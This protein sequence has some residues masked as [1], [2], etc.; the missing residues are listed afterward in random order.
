MTPTRER[1]AHW[2]R[3]GWRFRIIRRGDRRYIT[4]LRNRVERSLGPYDDALWHRIQAMI[5]PQLYLRD[6]IDALQK[7]VDELAA[8]TH[9]T[10]STHI[11]DALSARIDQIEAQI[12]AQ[13]SM[14]ITDELYALRVE[15][16]PFTC[17]AGAHK[18]CSLYVS[19]RRPT[20]VMQQYP[21]VTFDRIT[22]Q[23]RTGWHFRAHPDLCTL[24][25]PIDSL[26][27]PYRVPKLRLETIAKDLEVMKRLGSAY[28]DCAL[29]VSNR[30]TYFSSSEKTPVMELPEASTGVIRYHLDVEKH[31]A[32][33][34][35]CRQYYR[36][37][38]GSNSLSDLFKTSR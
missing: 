8:Q 36:T 21:N 1:L 18:Y 11:T 25:N 30:C 16:C 29:R 34:F 31:P 33:C 15:Q 32:T 5:A 23:N 14:G 19:V 24:C 27:A 20:E 17:T 28:T 7:R 22:L 3:E 13:R 9:S 35:V 37:R 6:T 4:R 26:L 38:E 2:I 12:A 10:Q